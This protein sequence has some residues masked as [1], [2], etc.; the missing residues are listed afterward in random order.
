M[1]DF[2]QQKPKVPP[3]SQRGG[4]RFDPGAVHHLF[5]PVFPYF[6]NEFAFFAAMFEAGH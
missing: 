5:W 2:P 6:L 3:H 4:H 1:G